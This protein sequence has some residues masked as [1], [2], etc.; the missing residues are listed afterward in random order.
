MLTQVVQLSANNYLRVRAH[1]SLG[2]DIAVSAFRELTA[3]ELETID[4]TLNP[5]AKSYQI[6][7]MT[8][9]SHNNQALLVELKGVDRAFPLYGKFE[10]KEKIENA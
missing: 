5:T 7:L 10:F 6:E 9:L 2:A 3:Q 1:D 8:M 4:L